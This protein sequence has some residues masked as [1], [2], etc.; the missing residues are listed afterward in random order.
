MKGKGIKK[1]K[2]LTVDDMIQLFSPVFDSF[3]FSVTNQLHSM[4]DYPTA[5]TGDDTRAVAEEPAGIQ[6]DGHRA[7]KGHCIHQ[8]GVVVHWQLYKAVQ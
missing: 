7:L 3:L 4:V 6:T 1:G 8:C 2:L 5:H